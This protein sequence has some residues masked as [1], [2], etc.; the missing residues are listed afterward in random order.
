MLSEARHLPSYAEWLIPLLAILTI[1]SIAIN[2]D[3][4][5]RGRVP[6]A[7]YAPA[8]LTSLANVV[9]VLVFIAAPRTGLLQGWAVLCSC[10]S[11]LAARVVKYD[12][13]HGGGDRYRELKARLADKAA[14]RRAAGRS[15]RG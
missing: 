4:P 12:R 13:E 2:L 9:L 8:A 6:F 11:V 15:E 1:F 14:R 3:Y 5:A 10:A 7:I